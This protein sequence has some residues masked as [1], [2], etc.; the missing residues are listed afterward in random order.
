MTWG[1]Y[2]DSEVCMHTHN[3]YDNLSVA[4]HAIAMHFALT[5]LEYIYLW[6]GTIT[7]SIKHAGL[8]NPPSP[9]QLGRNASVFGSVR[10]ICI[11]YMPAS[12]LYLT[13]YLDLF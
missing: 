1:R 5:E 2:S 6:C 9:V 8:Y 3:A 7:E 10:A 12:C 4:S 11:P 13:I